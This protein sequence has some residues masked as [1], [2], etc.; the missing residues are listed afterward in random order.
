[1]LGFR[2]SH[3]RCNYSVEHKNAMCKSLK[4]WGKRSGIYSNYLEF[5]DFKDKDR[6]HF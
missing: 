1:M 5:S 3:S 6:D 4:C 2:K